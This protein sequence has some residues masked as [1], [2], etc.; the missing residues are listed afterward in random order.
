MEVKCKK[1]GIMFYDSTIEDDSKKL[2][3]SEFIYSIVAL[4]IITGLFY[5]ILFVVDLMES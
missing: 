5:F 4:V 1:C 3:V 2:Y